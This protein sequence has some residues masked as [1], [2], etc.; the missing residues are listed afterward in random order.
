MKYLLPILL[1]LFVQPAFAQPGYAPPSGVYCSCGPTT[2]V[3]SG[4]VNPQ[5]AAMPFVNGILVRVG[6]QLVEP[7]DDN[8]NW[9]L[10]DGQIAAANT[11]GKKIALGIGCGIATPPWVFT[12]GAQRLVTSVPFTDTIPVPWDTVFINRWTSFITAL[13]NRYQNDTTI[14]LVYIT[15]STGNGFEMQL[16]FVTTPTL[17]AAGYTDAKVIGEWKAIIDAFGNAFPNHYLSNDFHPVNGSNAVA[18]SVYAYAT[19]TLGNRYGANAWWFTQHNTTVYPSQYAILQQ[20]AAN[21][22]FTGVQMAYNGTADSASFGAGGMPGA[23]QLAV[24]N[25][26]CYWEVWNQDILNPAFDSLLSNTTCLST[27]IANST[28]NLTKPEI[29]PNP[30]PNQFTV[31]LTGTQFTVLVT[32]VAGRQVSTLQYVSDKTV[33]DASALNNGLYFV[34]VTCNGYTQ[35]RRIVVQH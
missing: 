24:S 11:Y 6:W 21:N 20:S 22:R 31:S 8:Y 4:S 16:P 12:A 26:I 7:T 35:T 19:A 3:G 30:T 25:N 29:Y 14:Q 34:H 5:I 27:G 15:A 28:G 9:N 13:G 2:G 33:I 23:L 17:A 32:D 18:D 10:I 1:L